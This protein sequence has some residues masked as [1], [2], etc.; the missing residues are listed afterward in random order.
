M[1]FL[2][3]FLATVGY[4]G[5]APVAPGTAG[6]LVALP[7]VWLIYPRLTSAGVC[8][9]VLVLCA[10]A[11]WAAHQQVS[12]EQ[13]DPQHVVVDELVGQMIAL[14]FIPLGTFT[15]AAGFVLFRIFDVFKP[16]PS[17]QSEKLPGGWGIVM[18]DMV[19][20]IYANLVLRIVIYFSDAFTTSG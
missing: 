15:I 5:Y 20:G 13:K 7:I 2:A 19:A 18:D 16:F 14:L 6:S 10:V 12:D 3:R 17:R 4:V 1:K 11:I 8:G 9:G